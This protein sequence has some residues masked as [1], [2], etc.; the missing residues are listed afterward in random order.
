MSSPRRITVLISGNG[1]NL[2][3][4]IDASNTSPLP[5]V[6][7]VKVISDRKDAF[8]L[9]RA[10]KARIPR[11]VHNIVPYKHL[12]DNPSDPFSSER[13]KAYDA[14]LSKHILSSKPDIVVCA[15][16]MRIVTPSLLN[17]LQDAKVPI[18]NVHPSLHGDLIGA[19]CIERAWEEFQAGKR[20]KTGI[21]IHHVIAEVDLG[22]PIVQEE[23]SIEGC[24]KLEDLQER[25]HKVEHTLIVEGTRKVL[26]SR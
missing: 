13:R 21:M 16:F 3:A 15:G 1:S 10:E 18:I 19:H 11:L 14:D 26:D 20:K 9:Q 6:E 17:P 2:Q 7:I 24:G 8:G 22:E 23:V 25:L 12:P 4:L 5:N